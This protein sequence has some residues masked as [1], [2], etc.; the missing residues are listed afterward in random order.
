MDICLIWAQDRNGAI[1]SKGAP[2]WR[3]DDDVRRFRE[4]TEQHPVVVGRRT[5]EALPP[6]LFAGRQAFVL[7]QKLASVP[8]AVACASLSDALSMAS[9][10]RPSRLFLVGGARVCEQGLR[11]ADRLYVMRTDERIADAVAFAPAIDLSLFDLREEICVD[12]GGLRLQEFC[13][14]RQLH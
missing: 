2:T 1:G 11:I 10:L 6:H 5:W 12:T 4:L 7:T 14:R 3:S 13:R 8:G 9:V